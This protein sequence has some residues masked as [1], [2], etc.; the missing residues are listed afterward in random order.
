MEP[1]LKQ[2]YDQMR[3]RGLAGGPVCRYRNLELSVDTESSWCG[4]G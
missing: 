4:T 3:R 2:S 1:E